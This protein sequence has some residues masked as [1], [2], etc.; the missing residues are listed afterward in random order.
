MTATPSLRRALG[1]W[2]LTAIGINQVIGAAIFLIPSQVAKPIGNW[3]PIFFAGA[4]VASLLVAL[5]FA[6]VSSRFDRTGGPYLYTRQAFGDFLGFEVGWMQWFTRVS[7]QASVINGIALALGL[8]WPVMRDGAARASMI[9]A[10]I[11][12][13]GY[14]NYRGIKESALIVNVLTVGKLVPLFVFIAIG[15]FHADWSRLAPLPEI[16]VE[17]ASTAALLLIFA[18]G[19]FDVI[20]VP[21]GEATNPRRDVPF[22]FVM[23]IVAVTI[24]MGLGQIVT[25]TVLP[26][27][28]ASTTPMADAAALFMG[29]LGAAM[30]TIGSVVSMTGNNAGQVLT[31]SRMLFGI[32]E[33]G[34]LPGW[35]ARVHPEYRTPSNAIW[36]T[37][38]VALALALSGSFAMLAV[39]SAVSRLVTYTGTCAATLALRRPSFAGRVQPATFVTPGGPLVPVLATLVSLGILAGSTRGQLLGGLWALAGGAVL[40]VA[41][42]VASRYASAEPPLSS[43]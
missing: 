11:A 34:A 36:F 37:S 43:S 9:T 6:E 26:D 30:I 10:L 33:N 20:S 38:L 15:L 14:V 41:H 28:A 32:A 35:F 3:S 4:G 5:C 27:V 17:E 7:S 29:P 40:Y 12:V 21:A 19:G 8:Y 2:D 18:F 13:L 31:G 39:A 25:Q 16:T 23:T 42:R 22:A 24:I 1:R